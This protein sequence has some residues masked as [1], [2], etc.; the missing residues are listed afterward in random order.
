MA[1]GK[2]SSERQVPIWI[3]VSEIAQSPGSP[4]YARLNAVLA[5]SGFEP[6]GRSARRWNARAGSGGSNCGSILCAPRM[7]VPIGWRQ[8]FD[9]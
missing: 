2:R 5:E 4:F 9:G 6:L 8:S 1:L 3:A 7:P